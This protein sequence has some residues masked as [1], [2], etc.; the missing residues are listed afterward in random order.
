MNLIREVIS[1]VQNANM[2]VG[3]SSG[4]G[5]GALYLFVLLIIFALL[6]VTMMQLQQ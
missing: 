2:K 1:L 3:N 4:N 5:L 6:G